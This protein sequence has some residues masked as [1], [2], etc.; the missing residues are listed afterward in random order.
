MYNRYVASGDWQNTPV[1]QGEEIGQ[2]PIQHTQASQA[3]QVPGTAKAAGIPGLSELAGSLRS[4]PESIGD[5]LGR[6]LPSGEGKE[7]PFAGIPVLEKLDS[8]D[9]LLILVLIFLFQES[10]DEE[11]LIILGLVLL[12]GL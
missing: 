10:E 1:W 7:N 6:L 12:M 9:L 8:G 4:L 2:E 11:W 3:S 5:L